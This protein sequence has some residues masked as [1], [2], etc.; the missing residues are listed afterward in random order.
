[1]EYDTPQPKIHTKRGKHA[2][3]KMKVSTYVTEVDAEVEAA[4]DL[5]TREVRKKKAPDA[6]QKPLKLLKRLTCLLKCY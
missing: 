5:V 2:I 1:M 6:L 4:T 3:K